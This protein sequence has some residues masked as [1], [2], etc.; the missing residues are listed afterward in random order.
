MADVIT[1]FKLETTQYES[2][3]RDSSKALAAVSKQAELAGNDFAKFT[4]S[5]VAAAQALGNTAVGAT[6]AKDKVKELV[7]AYNQVAKA[8]NALTDE[9]KK[10]DFGK[11]MAQSLDQLQGRIKEAKAEMTDTGGVLGQ[12]KDKFT[13]NI[14]ALKLF[15]VGMNAAK[16]ALD[17]AKDAFFASEATVDEWGRVM[18]SSKSLYE[19]FLTA[20]NTGDISGYLNRI[21]DIVAAARTAY[22]ELDRLGTMKTIQAPQISAQ[23]LENE[24]FRQMINTGRYIAPGDGRQA[25]MKNGQLLT[26]AQIERINQMLQ[27]GMQKI[28]GLVGNEVKQ[29]NRAID[30]VYNRQAK[31]LGISLNE[32]RK[33]TSSMVEFEKRVAGAAQLKQWIRANSIVDERTGIT[34]TPTNIPKELQQYRGWDVFRV[35]GSRYADLVNLIK[36]RDSQVG[37]MYSLQAQAY[38]SMNK[39]DRVTG[40]GPSGGGG[41]GGNAATVQEMTEMQK[42]QKQINDLTQEYVNISGT[43]TDEVKARQ[44][45]I[46]KEIALLQERNNTLKLYQEQAKGKLMGGNVQTQGL[47]RLTDYQSIKFEGIKGFNPSTTQQGIDN[48]T[49]SLTEQQKAWQLSSSAATA[50]GA[51]L[52]GIEDPGVK[53]AGMVM[54]AIASIALGFAQASASASTAGTGWGWLAW[55]AAGA[56]AMATT[57]ATIHSLTGYANGGIV[58]GNSYSGDNV[59]PVM[60]DAGELILNRSQQNNVANAI[61]GAGMQ[62]LHLEGLLRGEN[63]WIA[64]NRY[65]K[66]TGQGEIV[67]W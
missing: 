26:P 3:L 63:I 8:Y 17:V 35:D 30:A 58:G 28:T 4:Q 59:G 7:D 50:F 66:R 1:R 57:I 33:G 34:R 49:K 18:D 52:A 16:A 48:L 60:L 23:Q 27:G 37:N 61:E 15:S 9:Q 41:G 55:L 20:L 47:G 6:N 65:T 40:G 51:A 24:R 56:S 2:K 36:Q 42:N 67:T 5:S 11:A 44:I 14:D 31:E 43:S 22:D 54:Q 38:K 10:S 19:G 25:T 53:A 62:N 29:T 45:E 46:R 64:A 13:I 21:N 12:L 32:F 39:A